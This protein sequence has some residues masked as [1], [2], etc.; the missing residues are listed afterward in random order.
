MLRKDRSVKKLIEEVD[1]AKLKEDC[2]GK[3]NM[4][5]LVINRNFGVGVI[6]R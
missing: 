3:N 6:W 4:L 5:E 1:K 2:L